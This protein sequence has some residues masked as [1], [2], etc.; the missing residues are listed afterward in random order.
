MSQ[1]GS[2]YIR[3]LPLD[4][5]G[6]YGTYEEAV[7]E[8]LSYVKAQPRAS[9]IRFWFQK[10]LEEPW[11]RSFL[12][13][14]CT[15][16]LLER[17]GPRSRST[18]RLTRRGEMFLLTKSRRILVEGLVSRDRFR[19]MVSII[20]TYGPIT[21]KEIAAVLRRETIYDKSYLMHALGW[22]QGLGLIKRSK[23]GFRGVSKS[24]QRDN[25]PA[26]FRNLASYV[27]AFRK[28][29]PEGEMSAFVMM[30]FDKTG[31][32]T[33]IFDEIKKTLQQYKI[34]AVRADDRAYS[35]DLFQNVQ[36]YMHASTIGIA[37]FERI[38]K[39]EFNPNV[40]LEVGY[41][42]GL[43]KPVCLLKESYLE[44]LNTDLL[45]R[46]YYEFDSLRPSETIGP[47]LA[48][49]L[50]AKGLVDTASQ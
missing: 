48:D 23:K 47:A 15:L 42:L 8:I 50:K 36:T 21:P 11:S 3:P 37:V 10:R 1:T 18:Y 45:G 31:V 13:T 16:G 44:R 34:V 35:D 7:F 38:T 26:A 39:K 40:A 27:E 17:F 24:E 25:A 12:A 46:V 33:S 41:M 28:D 20:M 29:H 49:W 19:T 9:D 30:R 14:F 32:H 6:L 43:G 22:M 4:S 5:W 2:D